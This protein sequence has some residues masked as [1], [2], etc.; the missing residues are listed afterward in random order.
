MMIGA[1]ILN[2]FLK[3]VPLRAHHEA[4]APAEPPAH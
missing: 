4:P 3:S 2:L 1:L